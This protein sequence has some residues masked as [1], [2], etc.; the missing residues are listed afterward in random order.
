ML[1]EQQLNG[2]WI[3]YDIEV[4]A[5]HLHHPRIRPILCDKFRVV[6]RRSPSNKTRPARAKKIYVGGDSSVSGLLLRLDSL[7][8]LIPAGEDTTTNY[9]SFYFISLPVPVERGASKPDPF[10]LGR[11]LLM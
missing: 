7:V 8:R 2:Q 5:F 3:S 9:A 6:C 10:I 1:W 4:N 11:S